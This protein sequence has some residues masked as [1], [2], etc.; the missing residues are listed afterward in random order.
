MTSA[1]T[2]NLFRTSLQQIQASDFF[3][4]GHDSSLGVR[5]IQFCVMPPWLA[6]HE[7]LVRSVAS[8]VDAHFDTGCD[9][10]ARR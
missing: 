2:L 10:A 6:M 9:R 1:M 3:N 5:P 7:A 4:N 8:C